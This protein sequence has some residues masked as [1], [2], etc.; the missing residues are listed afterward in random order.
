MSELGKTGSPHTSHYITRGLISTRLVLTCFQHDLAGPVQCLK[1]KHH[2]KCQVSCDNVKHTVL[3]EKM[4]TFLSES[5][6]WE[7]PPQNLV[8]G[9]N[10]KCVGLNCGKRNR[11]EAESILEL[12]FH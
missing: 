4:F 2:S 10:V 7:K 11:T 12:N 3:S 8:F 9:M 5:I 1:E 6:K